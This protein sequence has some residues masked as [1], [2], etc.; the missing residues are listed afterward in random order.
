MMLVGLDIGKNVH[1]FGNYRWKDLG[2]TAEPIKVPTTRKGFAIFTANL[3]RLLAENV[4]VWLGNE[5][6]G[7]YYE[8]WARA[9]MK[10]Y[11]D[12]IAAGRLNY[13][14]VNPHQVKQ[15][16]IALQRGRHRKT[17]AIDTQAIA[18]CLKLGDGARTARLPDAKMLRFDLWARRYRKVAHEKARLRNEIMEQISRL[19]PGALVNVK[20]FEK[21]HPEMVPPVPLVK[22]QHLDRKLVRALITHCPN[23]YEVREFS[24][25][26]MIEFLRE[27]MDRGGFK[28][29]NHVLDVAYQAVLPPPEI[30]ELLAK[31][32]TEDWERYLKIAETAEE[33]KEQ[34]KKLV[35]G[36]PAELLVSV[37]GI[38]PYLAACY[39]AAIHDVCRFPSAAHIWSFA[40]FDPIQDESG[41]AVRTGKISKRGDPAFRNTLF[42]IGNH[43]GKH[44]P[45]VMPVYERAL[46]RMGDK[47]RPA[48]H[49]A[50]KAN[51]LFFRMLRDEVPYDPN[52]AT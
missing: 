12:E 6:T 43:T 5:P 40:G 18:R 29:A 49:A 36:T 3:D 44:C 50:H 47:I 37:P 15:A 31:N 32:L 16:R 8:A 10:R 4:V 51:R 17:D 2:A 42:M 13:Q 24:R 23:P 9:I 26:E 46:A 34:A 7:I 33:L 28:T 52:H 45:H 21:A 27:Y 35:Q 41:D 14:F 39:M 38:G 48:I 25:D 1:V 30:A 22:T 20:R 11:A 19:W